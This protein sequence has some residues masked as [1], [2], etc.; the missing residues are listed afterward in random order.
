MKG[1][2]CGSKTLLVLISNLSNV[3][4][5]LAYHV[6]PY[7][8]TSTTHMLSVLDFIYM[9]LGHALN[10]PPH[11][12]PG[13]WAGVVIA[14]N[15]SS[16][17]AMAKGER[18]LWH[19][20]A[21]YHFHVEVVYHHYSAVLPQERARAAPADYTSRTP[22]GGPP[23]KTQTLSPDFI[24][25]KRGEQKGASLARPALVKLIPAEIRIRICAWQ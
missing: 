24:G 1:G 20:K 23:Q 19:A 21:E 15:N 5:T 4:S 6:C 25:V 8:Y 11:A 7:Y 14:I 17:M 22:G 18:E 16:S 3:A 9:F 12:R 2:Q 13:P 10:S